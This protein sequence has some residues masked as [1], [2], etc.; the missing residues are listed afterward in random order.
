M[1]GTVASSSGNA[2]IG[3]LPAAA[4]RPQ[5][6]KMARSPVSHT[7]SRYE[8]HPLGDRALLIEVGAEVSEA[9][10]DLVRR[11]D[12]RLSRAK[13]P[14]LIECVPA[15][16]SLAVHYDPAGVLAEDAAMRGRLPYDVLCEG[17]RPLLEGL[18]AEVAPPGRIVEIP[19]C[20]GGDHGED[21]AALALG[22][23]MS[24]E[25]FI[26]LHTAPTYFVGMLGFLPGFP[27]LG[28]MDERLVSA[29]RSTPRR[30]VPAGSVAIGGSHTG[31]Y[32][33]PSPG[34]W[35]LIGR[36]PLRLFD[37]ERRSPSL[38]MVG[39]RVRFVSIPAQAFD[40]RDGT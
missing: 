8:F 39:D 30:E 7:A 23:G 31:I 32:T 29:R 28:G 27:Y 2:G 38:L 24:A 4:H 10:A 15:F 14:G 25:Q 20:Y 1:R 17:I 40:T 16:C 12:D 21:L 37:L 34:G 13:L 6:R 26:A 22:R 18:D 35:H 19:V 3:P 33:F 9:S 11:I 36:T 5:R